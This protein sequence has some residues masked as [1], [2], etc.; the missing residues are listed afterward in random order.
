MWEMATVSAFPLQTT[1]G[2]GGYNQKTHHPLTIEAGG[3]VG[4]LPDSNAFLQG[5]LKSRTLLLSAKG[6]SKVPS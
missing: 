2:G 1:P 3:L 6:S 4:I 5:L